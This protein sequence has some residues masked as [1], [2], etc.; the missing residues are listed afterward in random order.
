MLLKQNQFYLIS[1]QIDVKAMI[2]KRIEHQMSSSISRLLK[3]A[4]STGISSLVAVSK[5]LDIICETHKLLI[6]QGLT[7]L[8]YEQLLLK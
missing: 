8:L 3:Y 2:L 4:Q 6:D 7:L 5:G 1:E